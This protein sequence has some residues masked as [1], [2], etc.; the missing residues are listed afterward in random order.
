MLSSLTLTGCDRDGGNGNDTGARIAAELDL[1]ELGIDSS[2]EGSRT[3]NALALL[4]SDTFT[5]ELDAGIFDLVM[6]RKGEDV[7]IIIESV[8]SYTKDGM[9]Y[10]VDSE[11]MKYLATELTPSAKAEMESLFEM[12]ED[13]TSDL[14][15]MILV[16]SGTEEFEGEERYY[17]EIINEHGSVKYYFDA[18]VLVGAQSTTRGTVIT[19]NMKI[20][21]LVPKDAFEFPPHFTEISAQEAE[22]YGLNIW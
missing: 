20:T 6:H 10:V 22:D 3:L 14:E 4:M 16:S 12:V 18:N 17:E 15:G 8:K 13:M 9:L 21:E 19:M 7:S 2:F 1:A 5:I 11:T